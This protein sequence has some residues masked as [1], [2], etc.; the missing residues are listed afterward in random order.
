MLSTKTLAA[1]ISGA[2]KATS[3][4]TK[5]RF[6]GFVLKKIQSKCAVL[7][8]ILL[9]NAK[10]KMCADQKSRSLGGKD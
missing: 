2:S 6:S 9:N 10:N 8:K 7:K 1:V 3:T 5:L 4:H